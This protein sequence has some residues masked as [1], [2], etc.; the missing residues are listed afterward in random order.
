MFRRQAV[1][2][3]AKKTR[4]YQTA[5]S[6]SRSGQAGVFNQ[7]DMNL[8]Y[9]VAFGSGS[10]ILTTVFVISFASND[11]PEPWW[12]P[13]YLRGVEIF[14]TDSGWPILGLS[15]ALLA[16]ALT[17]LS[18]VGY[19]GQNE[20]SPFKLEAMRATIQGFIFWS[21]SLA[22]LV[23]TG[24]FMAISSLSLFS[25]SPAEIETTPEVLPT[26]SG[27]TQQSVKLMVLG[28]SA[29]SIIASARQLIQAVTIWF[30]TDLEVHEA[31]RKLLVRKIAI[32]RCLI[33]R[34]TNQTRGDS[35]WL[36]SLRGGGLG[37]LMVIVTFFLVT[38]ILYADNGIT[39]KPEAAFAAFI[40]AW[41]MFIVGGVSTN[42][43]NTYFCGPQV[44]MK[45]T[46]PAESLG[47]WRFS[48]FMWVAGM[49][50][51]CS[52]AVIAG[53]I[54]FDNADQ[55]VPTK[56][57]ILVATFAPS[58]TTIIWPFR[59]TWS[60]A[61]ACSALKVM[62]A[63]RATDELRLEKL[64]KVKAPAPA[65]E[66]DSIWSRWFQAIRG[67]PRDQSN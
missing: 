62:V 42:F 8:V 58:L 45:T 51:V 36:A 20:F 35:F 67:R 3:T 2:Q 18:I 54:L 25:V 61:A 49:T 13:S 33:I 65:R 29:M 40:S 34:A 12:S 41:I 38:V 60:T 56:I 30:R 15:V 5:G 1:P 43:W 10:L 59:W 39:Y 66:N 14:L 22:S 11:S 64:P 50:V 55:N 44:D 32:R 7:R 9:P 37:I 57:A 17:A 31:E 47:R 48:M 16:A 27:F 24:S 26:T 6:A 53:R 63:L 23:A 21:V 4:K 46:G 28:L 52:P 19:R